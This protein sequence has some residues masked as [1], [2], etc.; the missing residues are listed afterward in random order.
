VHVAVAITNKDM[1]LNNE[2]TN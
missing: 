2:F 1:S